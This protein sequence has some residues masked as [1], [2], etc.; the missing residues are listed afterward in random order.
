MVFVYVLT[1]AANGKRYVGQSKD[2]TCRFRQHCKNARMGVE[3]ALY[4]AMRKHG[5]SSFSMV[6][7]EECQSKTVAD[8]REKHWI[9]ELNSR[10]SGHG[11]NLTEGGEGGSDPSPETRAKIGAASKARAHLPRRPISAEGL[12]NIRAGIAN[13]VFSDEALERIGAATSSR[14]V[15]EET[16]AKMSST[17][18]GRKQS[19][20]HVAKRAAARR[21]KLMPR[22]VVERIA[23]MKRGTKHTDEARERI[24]EG[25][26][27]AY[28]EGRRP[29]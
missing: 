16:R 23:A 7:V 11:Y 1:N 26:R 4:A 12:A 13:R 27:A 15:S 28:A 2:A 9:S 20:E 24:S 14:V 29:R 3:S 10:T 17:R 25:L 19:P 18:K 22:E 5:E 6:V 21:G 8:L